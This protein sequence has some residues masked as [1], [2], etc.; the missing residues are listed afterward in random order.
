MAAD[1]I[2]CLRVTS[3]M[4]FRFRIKEGPQNTA[5]GKP[6]TYRPRAVRSNRE[7]PGNPFGFS[8]PVHLRSKVHRFRAA[9]G[10]GCASWK[11]ILGF[12]QDAHRSKPVHLEGSAQPS[13]PGHQGTALD[14]VPLTRQLAQRRLRPRSTGFEIED[15]HQFM[16]DFSAQWTFPFATGAGPTQ[17]FRLHAGPPLGRI[18]SNRAR[19]KKKPCLVWARLRVCEIDSLWLYRISFSST[20][21]MGADLRVVQDQSLTSRNAGR[22]NPFGV[23]R[24]AEPWA[25]HPT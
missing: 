7:T 25:R 18:S 16:P 3:D 11:E 23:P 2:N 4:G 9:P 19:A 13:N 17:P 5:F 8:S 10:K 12:F 1:P 24:Y 6:P 20:H 21:I 22:A 15:I 14:P